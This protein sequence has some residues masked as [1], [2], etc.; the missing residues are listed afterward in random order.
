MNIRKLIASLW[1]D[2][3]SLIVISIV[4]VV[5][6]IFIFLTAAKPRTEAAMF[7]FTWPSQFQLL[8]NIKEVVEFGDGR[9]FLAFANSIF[10]TVASVTLIVLLAALVA[11]VLQRRRDRVASA[12]SSIMLAGLIIPPAVV[13]TIFVLQEIGL[14]R[15]LWG[16]IMVQVA[17]TMPFAI[18]VFRTF[19]A[20]IPGE[21]D[22]AA[23][24][25]GASPMQMFFYVI[26]PLLRPAIITVIVVSSVG[27]Y[28]DFTGPLYFLPGSQNVT[29]QV[30]L[31]SY[32]SQFTSQWNLLF[33]N[34]VLITIP[35]LIMFMF[36]QRQIVAGMTAGAI[37]G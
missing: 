14:Y 16:M 13:P 1:I 30:T 15:T 31:F 5:P 23:I 18:L 2:V 9:I 29:V 28:N 17:Y 3:V 33:A 22:E 34:V 26:L 11:F 35:P 25:D 24:I 4:F 21:I 37:K 6:F 10:I 32:I 19:M 12:V 20:S 27:I 7:E 36:F 8:E